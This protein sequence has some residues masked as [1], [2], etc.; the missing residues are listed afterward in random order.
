[1]VSP[2]NPTWRCLAPDYLPAARTFPPGSAEGEGVKKYLLISAGS[3][4]LVLGVVGIAV[5]LLPTTP[6][7]LLSSYC[8]LRSSQRLHGWLMGHRILGPP[9]HNY[10][11]R[12][13][14]K[15]STKIGALIYLWLTLGVS[16]LLITGFPIRVFLVAVGIAVSIHLLSLKTLRTEAP[17]DQ[18]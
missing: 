2:V 9:I 14:V 17:K 7:L 18:A 6:F 11:S 10:V 16:I 13:A 8:Y 5:P 3:I 15:R 1:M 12:R 4:F